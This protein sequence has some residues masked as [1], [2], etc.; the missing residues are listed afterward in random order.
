MPHCIKCGNKLTRDEIGLHKKLCNRGASEHLC[1][2]CLSA[3]F[4]VPVPLLREKIEQFRKDGCTLFR[5]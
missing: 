2:E 5:S 3:H 4:H 1:I